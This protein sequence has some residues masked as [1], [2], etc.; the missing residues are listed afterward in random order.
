MY[1]RKRKKIMGY[2]R[3]ITATLELKENILKKNYMCWSRNGDGSPKF[4]DGNESKHLNGD[5]KRLIGG[6]GKN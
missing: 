1:S 6:R 5:G 4:V 2:K 3:N